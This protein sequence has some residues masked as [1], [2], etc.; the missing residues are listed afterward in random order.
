MPGSNP[1]TEMHSG[2]VN[3]SIEQNASLYVNFIDFEKVF[4]SVDRDTLWD[5]MRHYG[6]AEK[7]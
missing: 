2:R 6:I 7:I 3:E 1:H 4:D 5:L